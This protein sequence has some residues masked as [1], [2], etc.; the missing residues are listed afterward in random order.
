VA[1]KFSHKKVPQTKIRRCNSVGHDGCTAWTAPTELI[2]Y[3]DARALDVVSEDRSSNMDVSKE[4]LNS[5]LKVFLEGTKSPMSD[6]D[7]VALLAFLW[8]LTCR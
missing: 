1:D 7:S 2:S 6:G 5:L 4:T 3:L 8:M